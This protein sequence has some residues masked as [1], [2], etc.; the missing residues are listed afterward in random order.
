MNSLLG[1]DNEFHNFFEG[2]CTINQWAIHLNLKDEYRGYC[3]YIKCLKIVTPNGNGAL[4]KQCIENI[5]G[6]EYGDF[7]VAIDMESNNDRELNDLIEK[8]KYHKYLCGKLD[9]AQGN[10]KYFPLAEPSPK[11][12]SGE[13]YGLKIFFGP[14]KG[15]ESLYECCVKVASF[16]QN[17]PPNKEELMK[18]NID[19]ENRDELFKFPLEAIEKLSDDKIRGNIN[20]FIK[21]VSILSGDKQLSYCMENGKSYNCELIGHF[22]PGIATLIGKNMEHGLNQTFKEVFQRQNSHT[23]K[24]KI[25]N[26]TI[27]LI[28]G[29]GISDII[30]Y[31]SNNIY[32]N[33]KDDVDKAKIQFVFK[34]TNDPVPKNGVAITPEQF[35]PMVVDALGDDNISPYSGTVQEDSDSNSDCND[36]ESEQEPKHPHNT[37]WAGAPGTGKSYT[38]N[39]EAHSQFGAKNIM[40]VTFHPE[41]TYYDFV[42]TYRPKMSKT[43]EG[44][45]KR[46][47][48]YAFVPGPFAKMLKKALWNRATDYCLI[49]EEIN[50]ANTAAVFG[51][52]FQLL[53]RASEDSEDG[54]VNKHESEYAICPSEELY[55]YLMDEREGDEKMQGT[56]PSKDIMNELRLPAN[57][58]IWATMNSADQGVFPMDTALKRRWSFVNMDIDPT[59]KA[60]KNDLWDQLRRGINELLLE[61]QVQEDKLMGYYFLKEEERKKDLKNAVKEKV[62]LYL[63]EDAAKPFKTGIF[64][65][66]LNTCAKLR[67]DLDLEKKNLGIF[68]KDLRGYKQSQEADDTNKGNE[69]ND[70]AI[71][72]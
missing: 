9:E 21:V 63:F 66:K 70:A 19:T 25:G 67:E 50:R 45:K 62:L 41:Y 43:E 38:L 7:A 18:I 20:G 2:K 17:N 4:Y 40:R 60:D 23:R 1:S 58:Y 42:G 26:E 34:Y 11:E 10:F 68:Q 52:V 14:C 61:H 49:I 54:S 39:R 69:G 44:D 15:N 6:F 12:P 71:N 59:P 33:Y 27:S 53:D 3:S 22:V 46:G 31:F 8:R 24:F 51:D 48:E 13:R 56:R 35:K 72:Q 47:I 32:P 57:L 36:E 55:E 28:C 64:Q 30:T 29:G 5:D 37:I 65:T 16:I